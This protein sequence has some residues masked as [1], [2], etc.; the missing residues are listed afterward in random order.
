MGGKSY[1]LIRKYLLYGE[2]GFLSRCPPQR[3]PYRI[4]IGGGNDFFTDHAKKRVQKNFYP[5]GR[6]IATTVEVYERKTT[7]LSRKEI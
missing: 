1:F 4:L 6:T 2:V 5:M 7:Q 3:F